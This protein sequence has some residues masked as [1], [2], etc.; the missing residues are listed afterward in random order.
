MKQA[1]LIIAH[2]EL[3][4]VQRIISHF[5]ADFD[6]FIHIDTSCREQVPQFKTAGQL[7]IIRLHHVEW[8]NEKIM[9]VLYDLMAVAAK[10]G[11]YSYY[12][13]ITGNCYPSQPLSRFKQFFSEQNHNNYIEYHPMPRPSWGTEGG[14]DRMH[15]YWFGIQH[16][17]VRYHHKL[18]NL[19]L[20]VQRKL[21]F[22]RSLAAWGNLYCGGWQAS[23]S[24]QGVGTILALPRKTLHRRTRFTHSCEEIVPQTLLLNNPHVQCINDSLHLS[25]WEDNAA[26]P[27]ILTLDD[28]LAIKESGAF[29]VRKVDPTLSASLL[30]AIDALLAK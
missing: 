16:H 18:T 26:S 14:L 12:H 7:H 22:R 24:S 27:K 2:K 13:L 8:G 17:D 10:Y 20:K 23:L 3:S 21:G 30:E 5:D 1:I 29:F 4:F 9:W 19:L 6:I 15:Y 11:P 28:L 25:L